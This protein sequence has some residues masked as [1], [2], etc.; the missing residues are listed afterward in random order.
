MFSDK[1]FF[2]DCRLRVCKL[3][4]RESEQTK[5]FPYFLSRQLVSWLLGS[6]QSFGS[7]YS[8]AHVSLFTKKKTVVSF[9]ELSEQY[10]LQK[11]TYLIDR[12]RV[13]FRRFRPYTGEYGS[14]KTPI[15]AHFM[16][17]R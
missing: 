2:K 8:K 16:H 7:M 14:M 3:A 17:F 9:I 13:F 12:T 10:S 4:I 1:S 15:P 6:K 5:Y 11:Q